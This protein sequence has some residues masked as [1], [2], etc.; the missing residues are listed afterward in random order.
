M[1]IKIQSDLDLQ[2]S[3]Y[4]Q[5]YLYHSGDTNTYIKF[6]A[7]RIRLIVGGTTKFDSNSSYLSSVSNDN[8]SGTDLAIANGGTGASTAS[9]ARTNL[10]LG[11][12]ATSAAT[13]FVAVSGDTMTGDLT[14]GDNQVL[15]GTGNVSAPSAS[16][17]MAGTRLLLYPNS[18]P[19]HYAIGIQSG[20]MWFTSDGGYVWYRDATTSAMSLDTGSNLS[21][22]GNVTGANLN[23][24]NWDTAYGWG[25]HS[26]AGYLTSINNGNWSGTDL[27]VANGGTGASTASAARTNLGLGTAATSAATDFLAAGSNLSDLGDVA[28]SRT[29]LGL[30][31]AA[32]QDKSYFASASHTQAFSTITSTPTTLAG[33]GITDAF[34]G[35]YSSLSGKPTLGTLAAL[36]SVNAATITDNSVGAAEL[37]VSG[38]GTTAQFLRSDGD[39]TFSWATP[40]VGSIDWTE[41][42]GDQANINNSGFTNDAGYVTSSGVTSVGGTGSIN[43][44]TL[45]GTVTS[46]GNLTLGGT[47]AI[48]NSD[49]SG[50]DLSIANGGT[51]ASTAS[52]ARTNLGLGTAATSASTDFVAVTGDSMNG[53]LTMN[54]SAVPFSF[55]ESGHTGTG[56]YWRM[57][58]DGGNIRFDVDTT[59][60]NGDGTFTSY[61]DVLLLKANGDVQLSNYG[62]GILK[63]DSSGNISLDTNTYLTAHPNISAAS[64]SDNSGRTYIQDI[65]L[66]S[67]GHV[68]GITTA[69]ETVT[70]TNT[71][72]TAGTGLTLTGTQFSVTANTYAA[73]SHSHS[74]ATTSAAGFMSAADKTKLDG[75]AT[76]ANNYVHPTS[77]GNKHIP[78]GG[79][80]GQF[81]KYSS[82]GTAVWATPSYTTNT[83]TVTSVGISGSETTGTVTLAASGAASVSQSGSTVTISAT[84][85]EYSAA[86]TSVAGLM[87]STDKSKLDGISTGADV[88][89]SWVPASDPGYLTA[90]PSISAATSVNN[91]G[92]T[93]IQDITLDSNGHI[94]AITSATETVVNTNTTYSAGSGLDLSGTTFSVETDLRDGITHVGVSSNNYI[95]FDETNNRIDFYAGNVH[96]ARMESDGD[97]HIKGDVIAFS[98]IFS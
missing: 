84:N 11:T 49:W 72:Y 75:V 50:T 58:L 43:G 87:S 22:T 45:T 74:D 62:A 95:T 3:I 8:W 65:T 47:L 55:I 13:D 79:A 69:T 89:P 77:A 16:D 44:L 78:S 68:T 30:G 42:Q 9:A 67:N 7:D 54:T 17:R 51:G 61:T 46:T 39:G 96:V 20:N 27:S 28:E 6:D 10:G 15:F 97:L 19:N 66:D 70:N 82:S 33:Y 88:T 92:R 90:H 53:T 26:S 5:D 4:L 83:D 1:G 23:V 24:S 38:N 35:A 29:N 18:A 34:D 81:L 36:N 94:T 73:S 85:T 40:S 21:V 93:Y 12:A 2:G 76:S 31:S 41:I 60:T 57:P 56:K 14:M 98:S 86:T 25:D 63:T 52:G 59:N 37:N 32:T 91:S 80:A 48:S 64:S 71:T